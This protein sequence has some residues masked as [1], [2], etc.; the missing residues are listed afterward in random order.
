MSDSD[1]E[2]DLGAFA[3]LATTIVVDDDEQAQEEAQDNAIASEQTS[4]ASKVIPRLEELLLLRDVESLESL[5]ANGGSSATV[6]EVE[7][8]TMCRELLAGK[9]LEVLQEF[10]PQDLSLAESLSLCMMEGDCVHKF[11]AGSS[12]TW[13]QGRMKLLASVDPSSASYWRSPISSYIVKRT[14]RGRSWITRR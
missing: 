2:D 5:D 7:L 1:S 9:H 13:A 8:I 10:S 12:L 3:F 11:G 6:A 4:S 14:T